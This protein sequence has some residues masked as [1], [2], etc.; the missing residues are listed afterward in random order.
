MQY[1]LHK[2]ED[3]NSMQFI[4]VKL[5]DVLSTNPNSIASVSFYQFTSIGSWKSRFDQ[6]RTLRTTN[7]TCARGSCRCWLVGAKKIHTKRKTGFS[8]C[9]DAVNSNFCGLNMIGPGCC[10]ILNSGL[11]RVDVSPWSW[12]F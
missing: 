11:V 8:A 9:K 4:S 3:L 5:V 12:T 7:T 2:Q 1:S 10:S 6:H